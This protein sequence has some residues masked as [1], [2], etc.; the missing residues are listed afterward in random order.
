MCGLGYHGFTSSAPANCASGPR[1]GA[2]PLELIS[3]QPPRCI[4]RQ[5]L[6]KRCC[7][8]SDSV[9]LKDYGWGRNTFQLEENS[10]FTVSEQMHNHQN[11]RKNRAGD[12]D[13]EQWLQSRQPKVEKQPPT[14]NV[15][16]LVS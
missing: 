1:K 6:A 11:A 15:C 5:D 12:L 16:V 4:A 9:L 10:P 13:V 14:T 2:D 7:D 3:P 8:R